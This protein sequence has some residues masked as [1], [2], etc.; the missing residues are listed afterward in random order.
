VQ[1]VTV[2]IILGIVAAIAVPRISSGSKNAGE[3]SL[4]MMIQIQPLTADP[5]NGKGWIYN[6]VT[7]EIIANANKLGSDGTPYSSW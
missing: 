5:P 3:N 2:M 4:Q 7:G 6:R 1:L